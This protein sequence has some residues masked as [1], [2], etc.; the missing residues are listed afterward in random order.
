MAEQAQRIVI[1]VT[2]SSPVPELWSA[3]MQC[4]G[5]SPA[6]ILALFVHSDRWRRAASLPFTRE[7]SRIGGTVADFTTQRAEQLDKNAVNEIQRRIEQLASKSGLALIFEVLADADQERVQ[8]LVGSGSSV[9]VAPSFITHRP[10]YSS[11]VQL[12]CQILL[13]EAME[14]QHESK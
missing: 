6:E 12:D 14:E 13:V 8:Q 11:F 9:I 1:A 10:I 2:E 4:L 3:A 7:I 5:D